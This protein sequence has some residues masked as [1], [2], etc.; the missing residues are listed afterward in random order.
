MRLCDTREPWEI[1]EKLIESGW[2]RKTLESGDFVFM[3]YDSKTVGIT[4]KTIS[5]LIA[6]LNGKFSKQ[7]EVMLETFDLNIILREGELRWDNTGRIITARG[8]ET[9]TVNLVRN[10]LRTWQDRGF[11]LE[12]TANESDTIHR[13][14]QLYAYYQKPY[15]TGGVP[16]RSVGDNRVLAF[17]VGCH[18]KT[19]LAVLDT[20]YS[21]QAIANA[22]VEQ[23]IDVPGVGIKRAKLIYDHF[24]R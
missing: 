7:L 15:H 21:L 14:N 9:Y 3:S 17:P 4:R 18:G 16:F 2:E 13:L 23:L 1:Q 24:R 19:A 11:T 5:D 12:I 20:F 6:S 10:Y 22:E 8:I